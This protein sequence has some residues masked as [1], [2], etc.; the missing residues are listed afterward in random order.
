MT[1]EHTV[2]VFFY[3]SYINFDVLAEVDI[4]KRHF[5]VSSV[6]G[7]KLTISPLANLKY[8]RLGTVYGILTQLTHEE[9]HRLYQDHAKEK[10]GGEY[11]PEAVIVYQQRGTYTPALCYISHNMKAE[12]AASAYVKKILEPAKEYGFP[13]WYLN[14]IAS[15][16]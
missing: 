11:L 5:E 3:G 16:Q 13:A 6:H 7:Y 9:L 10:L 12:K 14:Q 2:D 15:F 1:T 4:N 8:K